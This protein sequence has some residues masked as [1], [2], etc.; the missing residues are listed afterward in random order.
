VGARGW[1]RHSCRRGGAWDQSPNFLK[2]LGNG[3]DEDLV[4]DAVKS[5]EA[6]PVES[7]HSN[8]MGEA[9]HVLLSSAAGIGV[10]V[11]YHDAARIFFR[12][13]VVVACDLSS[14]LVEAT[15]FFERADMQA[16]EKLVSEA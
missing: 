14:R 10:G 3:S 16:A 6:H 8:L 2:D 11:S 4:C 13:L 15:A 1:D 7:E 12:S 5:A 9:G